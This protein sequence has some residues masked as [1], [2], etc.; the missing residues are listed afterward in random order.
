MRKDVESGSPSAFEH[1]YSA[2]PPLKNDH[3]ASCLKN[4]ASGGL[5]ISYHCFSWV[6]RLASYCG[7]IESNL[8]NFR[9]NSRNYKEWECFFAR[10]APR[11]IAKKRTYKK[12]K[13]RI[14]GLE[15][16]AGGKFLNDDLLEADFWEVGTFWHSPQGG[17]NILEIKKNY[18]QQ[19][20][21]TIQI[22]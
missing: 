3:A 14:V 19:L 10:C 8:H 9:T 20:C 16:F 21:F 12:I 18:A 13:S 11:T 22:A 2:I 4:P 15:F 7:H 17:K 5:K 6:K 1:L